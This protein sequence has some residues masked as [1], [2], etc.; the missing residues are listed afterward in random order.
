M[1]RFL[2]RNRYF[3]YFLCIIRYTVMTIAMPFSSFQWRRDCGHHVGDEH[4]DSA[5]VPGCLHGIL[6]Q[7]RFR[8]PERRTALIAI[9]F[10]TVPNENSVL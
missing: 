1:K 4:A 7:L 5:A 9:V 3:T 2:V 8:K 10:F 6:V